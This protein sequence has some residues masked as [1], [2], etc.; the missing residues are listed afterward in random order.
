VLAHPNP[1][2]MAMMRRIIRVEERI[3][4]IRDKVSAG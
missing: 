1:P 2:R 3:D 4:N